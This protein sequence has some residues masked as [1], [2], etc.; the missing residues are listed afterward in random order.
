MPAAE[1]IEV[2][3]GWSLPL[4]AGRSPSGAATEAAV[5]LS[6]ASS[7]GG[8]SPA[9]GEG[10]AGQRQLLLRSQPF[11]LGPEGEDSGEGS[12]SNS[13]HLVL[14]TEAP[15]ARRVGSGLWRSSS[16]STT[17]TAADPRLECRLAARV[18]VQQHSAAGGT[19]TASAVIVTITAGCF[20]SNLTGL[21]LAVLAEGAAAQAALPWAAAAGQGAAEP[22]AAGEHAGPSMAGRQ[23]S[24]AAGHDSP[25]LTPQSSASLPSVASVGST[26]AA[27][28]AGSGG[29]SAARQGTLLPHAA[30][31][32]LLALW[33]AGSS[34]KGARARRQS[35]WGSTSDM[36]RSFSGGLLPTSTQPAPAAPGAAAPGKP[37]LRVALVAGN[38]GPAGVGNLGAA[39]S[40]D[41]DAELPTPHT[42]LHQP[43]G[44]LAPGGPAEAPGHCWSAALSPY[45]AA[46]RQRLYLQPPDPPSSSGCEGDSGGGGDGLMLT[47]RVL[48]A[49][50]SFH[51][52]LFR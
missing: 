48:L 50:G 39:A 42:V 29:S 14:T 7:I 25:L 35:S 20:L 23:Q 31:V 47:Y 13:A 18:D 38:P 34:S 21:P 27:P 17:D 24:A 37:A 5:L 43:E 19:A 30:T 52:V 3:A 44:Q 41:M 4:P 32:P 40:A 2:P 11:S 6:L 16:G 15:P 51:L 36:L 28:A 8:A 26:T 10:Q 49:R 46:G 45:A 9:A 22:G 12:G 1:P 33:Q